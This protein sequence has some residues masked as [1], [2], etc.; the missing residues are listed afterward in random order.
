MRK[1]LLIIAAIV[2]ALPVAVLLVLALTLPSGTVARRVADRAES[3]LDRDVTIGDVGVS[4]WPF[5]VSLEGVAVAGLTPADAPV[6]SIAKLVL[7]P[8]LMPLFKRQLVVDQ[9]HLIEPRIDIAVD[10]A[11]VSNLPT[12]QPDSSREPA[13]GAVAFDVR[14]IRIERGTIALNDARTGR[15][16]RL[17]GIDQSLTLIGDLADGRLRSIALAGELAV[18]SIALR[19]PG[20]DDW[21]ARGLRLAVDHSARLLAD[22]GTL[23]LDSLRVQLQEVALRGAGTVRGLTA[24]DSVRFLDLRFDAEPFDVAQLIASLPERFTSRL[25]DEQAQLGGTAAVRATIVGPLGVDTFPA[26]QGTLTLRDAAATRSGE[27]LLAGLTGDIFFSNDSVTSSGLRGSALGEPLALSFALTQPADPIVRFDLDGAVLLETLSEAGLLP[28]SIPAVR[29]RVHADLAGTLQPSSIDGSRVAGTVTLERFGTTTKK[30]QTVAIDAATM[31]LA[32]D[33]IRMTPARVV[34]AGQAL[35]VAATINDWMPRA[36]GDSTA[37]PV[38]RF[39]VRGRRF[40][41]QAALGPAPQPTFSQLVFARLANSQIDGRPAE[42]IATERGAA[43][44]E[45]PALDA[46]GTIR[47][48]TVISAG[49][50]YTDVRA[51][52]AMRPDQLMIEQ[53]TFGMMGGT[54]DVSAVL[55]PQA[56]G[57]GMHTL[58]QAD[59][60]S[61]A[62]DQFLP[63]FTSFSERANGKL[64]LTGVV[65]LML[66]GNLLPDRETVQGRGVMTLRD[67]RLVAWPV[68]RQ[69]GERLGTGAFDTLA[70]REFTG[71]FDVAGPMIRFDDALVASAAGNARVAGSFTFAGEVDFGVEARLPAHITSRAGSMLAG[72]LATAAGPSD[73]IPVGVRVAGMWRRP[74]VTPDL[75][76]ARANVVNAARDAAAREAEQLAQQGARAIADRLGIAG[77]DSAGD[78]TAARVPSIDSLGASVEAARDSVENRVRDRLRNIF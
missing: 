7:R 46:R 66:D 73:E 11:G 29:G 45:L 48:D 65:E 61:L 40:D 1:R 71:G 68:L 39:D 35:D 44:P 20:D 22:S 54:G 49:V 41:V 76:Q 5:G 27:Q 78:S 59:M 2:V 15:A 51:S 26:V 25:R 36:F 55:T 17:D 72:A 74:N 6:V 12:I 34:F 16:V 19:L 53:A 67:A 42:A 28:D 8:R 58:V 56:D 4:L 70:L 30:G 21:T 77:A 33:S 14:D 63:R 69:L 32:G 9:L 75:S 38:V 18:D 52:I 62:S 23:H 24:S 43:P 31:T 10:S 47:I 64:D 37:L 3:M 57:S 60:R 50:A 13:S